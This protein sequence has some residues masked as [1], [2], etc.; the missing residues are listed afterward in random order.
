M[1]GA[2]GSRTCDV[3]GALA[4]VHRGTAMFRMAGMSGASPVTSQRFWRR[5]T[6]AQPCSEWRARQGAGPV[7]SLGFWRRY[8]GA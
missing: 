1:A 5:Y 2:S 3:A 7:T 6:G 8:T 4:Q